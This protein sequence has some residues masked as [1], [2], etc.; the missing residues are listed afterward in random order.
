MSV[1]KLFKLAVVL[2]L[3]L[4]KTGSYPQ[5]THILQEKETSEYLRNSKQR[6]TSDKK[7][8]D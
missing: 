4:N 7:K 5:G 8:N 6:S 3:L 2:C 1:F